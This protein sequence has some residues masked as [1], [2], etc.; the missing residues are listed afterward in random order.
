[1]C[2]DDMNYSEILPVKEL[3]HTGPYNLFPERLDPAETAHSW[4][5]SECPFVTTLVF[6]GFLPHANR[7]PYSQTLCQRRLGNADI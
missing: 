5:Y 1:M 4:R 7:K 3:S 2:H 6:Y